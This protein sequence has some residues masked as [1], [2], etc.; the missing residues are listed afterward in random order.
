MTFEEALDRFRQWKFTS[1]KAMSVQVI[2]AI[3]DHFAY[4]EDCKV[5]YVRVHTE[6]IEQLSGNW[7]PP[8]QVKIERYEGKQELIMTFKR[9]YEVL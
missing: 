3:L 4:N 1:P 6:L 2:Q 8:V 5:K 9:E 7:S